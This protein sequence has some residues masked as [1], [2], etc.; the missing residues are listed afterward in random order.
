MRVDKIIDDFSWTLKHHIFI[1]DFDWYSSE[2]KN[3][4]VIL[5]NK[6]TDSMIENRCNLKSIK[7][8]L[9]AL[10]DYYPFI[11]YLITEQ[12]YLECFMVF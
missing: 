3:C 12:E 8:H 4:D 6:I 5:H 10:N 7:I 9:I 1:V 11:D 2:K